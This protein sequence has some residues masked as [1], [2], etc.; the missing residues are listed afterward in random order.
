MSSTLSS[1]HETQ[2]HLTS[3]Q[4]A[5]YRFSSNPSALIGAL[6][7][8]SVIIGAIFAPVLAPSPQ[9]AGAHVDFLN[10]HSPPS[11][12]FLFGTDNAGRDIFSRVLF[13]YRVS[14]GLVIGVLGFAVPFGVLLG[15]SLIHI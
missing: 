1:Q 6:I 5:W 7:V 9:S 15:L 10:R 2:R 4:M 13:G 3:R 11:W 8:I 12:E 14:L